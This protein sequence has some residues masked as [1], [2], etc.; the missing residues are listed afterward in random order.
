MFRNEWD[1]TDW[2]LPGLLW[3]SKPRLGVIFIS[4]KRVGL[5]GSLLILPT[6]SGFKSEQL[7]CHLG[8]EGAEQFGS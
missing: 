1:I 2:S 8:R 6:S 5:R 4:W 3:Q 7:D